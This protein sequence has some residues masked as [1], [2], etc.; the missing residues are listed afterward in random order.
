MNA[1]RG[2]LHS[3]NGSEL[4]IVREPWFPYSAP[5]S[6]K[7]KVLGIKMGQQWLLKKKFSKQ[8]DILSLSCS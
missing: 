5:L 3:G 2:V 4:A 6:N 8:K 7:A 1:N